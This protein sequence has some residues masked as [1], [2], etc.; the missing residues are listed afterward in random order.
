MRLVFLGLA[1]S[2]IVSAGV[3]LP[4]AAEDSV[5]IPSFVEETASAG[6]D[7]VY[8]GEWEYMV[9]GGVATFDCNGDRL[10][11]HVAG[12]R[13]LA[14]QILPQRQ[15]PRRCACASRLRPA[16]SSWTR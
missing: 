15:H 4:A 10:R 1:L 7:S 9:G 2:A 12:R 14:G 16:V 5:A 11:R 13:Y 6:I 3:A 8:A